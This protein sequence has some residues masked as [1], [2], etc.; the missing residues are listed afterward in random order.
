MKILLPLAILAATA[1][2]QTISTQTPAPCKLTLDRSPSVRGL[3][4]GMLETDFRR[5]TGATSLLDGLTYSPPSGKP[6]FENIDRLSF[7]FYKDRLRRLEVTYDHSVLWRS[8]QEF[9]TAISEPLKLPKESWAFNPYLD[10][11]EMVCDGFKVIA[12]P[13][14]RRIELRDTKAEAALLAEIKQK[15]E[16]RKKTFKP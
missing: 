9:A 3:S 11:A 15:E 6:G 14:Y 10:N 13:G 4:L 5:I 8:A 7:D 12:W 16:D 2:S 1:Y